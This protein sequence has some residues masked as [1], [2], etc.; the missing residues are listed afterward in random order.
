MRVADEPMLVLLND[1]W[2]I[3]NTYIQKAVHFTFYNWYGLV[4]I[5]SRAL[6]CMLSVVAY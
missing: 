3:M 4:I 6:G 1:S 5:T 2:P